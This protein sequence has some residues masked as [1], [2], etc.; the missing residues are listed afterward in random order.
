MRKNTIDSSK[1]TDPD[2]KLRQELH[3]LWDSCDDEMEKKEL[4]HFIDDEN[5]PKMHLLEEDNDS[6]GVE[7]VILIGA[8]MTLNH[9]H[10]LVHERYAADVAKKVDG[11][12]KGEIEFRTITP[13]NMPPELVDLLDGLVTKSRKANAKK[14]KEDK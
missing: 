11:V 13:A 12:L 4:K 10:Q 7:E 2:K 14:R 3:D 6:I 1:T 5:Q 8:Y 9:I